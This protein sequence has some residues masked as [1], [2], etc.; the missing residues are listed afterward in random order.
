M[1]IVNYNSIKHKLRRYLFNVDGNMYRAGWSPVH[2]LD[3]VLGQKSV[4]V[5]NEY[6]IAV[7]N[8]DNT[9]YCYRRIRDVWGLPLLIIYVKSEKPSETKEGG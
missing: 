6:H 2:T 8:S 9:E 5:V 7:K 3:D 1:K 4:D